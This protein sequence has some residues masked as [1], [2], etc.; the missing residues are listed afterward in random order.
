MALWKLL[1]PGAPK[2]RNGTLS[3]DEQRAFEQTTRGGVK[4]AALAGALLNN[5]DDKKGQG[6]RHIKYFKE[7]VDPWYTHFP[8]TNNT[9]FGSHGDA[10]ADLIQYLDDHK[11]YLELIRLSKQ[12]GTHTQIE[13]N[14]LQ[15][16]NNP[17]TITELCAMVLYTQ[18][19]SKPYMVHVRGPGMDNVLDLGPFHKLVHEFVSKIIEEPGLL[20]LEDVSH[21]KGTL[22]G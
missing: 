2:P 4:V 22:D 10:A 5:K 17:A 15:A 3:E 12:A 16:L 20:V 18:A 1:D 11:A 9:R 21:V 14:I 8:D 13:H 6:D 7:K 19:V